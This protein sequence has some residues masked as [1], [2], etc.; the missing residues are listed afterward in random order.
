M[1]N[2]SQDFDLDGRR[3]IRS[4]RANPKQPLRRSKDCGYFPM[5]NR[6]FRLKIQNHKSIE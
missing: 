4:I 3:I 5:G 6:V 1:R 2:D